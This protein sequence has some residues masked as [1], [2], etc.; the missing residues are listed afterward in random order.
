MAC[1]WQ[2]IPT[3][4]YWMKYEG[5][6]TDSTGCAKC[7]GPVLS[8]KSLDTTVTSFLNS[9]L[10]I[11]SIVKYPLEAHLLYILSFIAHYSINS[12]ILCF[13]KDLL[14]AIVPILLHS[15]LILLIIS[16]VEDNWAV[17]NFNL[18]CFGS[19]NSQGMNSRGKASQVQ[20]FIL[21][22][23]FVWFF[24]KKIVFIF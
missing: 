11:A 2:C 5:K 13:S 4:V 14:V 15:Y 9:L 8:L 7:N 19:K 23:K 12:S 16:L 24:S 1:V 21:K 6:S 22:K 3:S 10:I 17:Y 20:G 18:S